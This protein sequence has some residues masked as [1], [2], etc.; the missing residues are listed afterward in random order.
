MPTND[1]EIRLEREAVIVVAPLFFLSPRPWSRTTDMLSWTRRH[2]DD[3]TQKRRMRSSFAT[4]AR[5]FALDVPRSV[6]RRADATDPGGR[7]T[8]VGSVDIA[9]SSFGL[10]GH[11]DDKFRSTLISMN[12]ELGTSLRNQGLND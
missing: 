6:Y 12:G 2:D 5:P 7:H 11:L 1:A 8:P 3:K 4:L 9:R 10:C